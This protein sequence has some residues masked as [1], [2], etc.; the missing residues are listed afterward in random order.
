[1][2][3]GC[4]GASSGS[5]RAFA[6]QNGFGRYRICLYVPTFLGHPSLL[7]M[8]PSDPFS[9]FLLVCCRELCRP[10][11]EGQFVDLAIEVE[12]YLVVLVVYPGAGIDADI[13]G[14]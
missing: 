11:V 3:V 13:E 10:K 7:V 8:R 14:F 9:H 1:M 5:R 6:C 12:G 4:G 2:M